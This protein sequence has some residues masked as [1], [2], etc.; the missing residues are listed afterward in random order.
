MLLLFAIFLFDDSFPFLRFVF[1]LLRLRNRINEQKQK[2]S[3][4]LL[5]FR[6]TF[7]P[8]LLFSF[9]SVRLVFALRR[10]L[11]STLPLK[12]LL[13]LIAATVGCFV[14]SKANEFAV[15]FFCLHS[16][17]IDA[18][19]RTMFWAEKCECV[20][21]VERESAV[22]I[23]RANDSRHNI[24]RRWSDDNSRTVRQ[25]K[26]KMKTND[27]WKGNIFTFF[28]WPF[29]FKHSLSSSSLSWDSLVFQH[30]TSAFTPFQQTSNFSHAIRPI[31]Y[32]A[33]FLFLLRFSSFSSSIRFF[34]LFVLFP[35]FSVISA[36]GLLQHHDFLEDP[37]YENFCN[38]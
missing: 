15:I 9:V 23:R 5:I 36:L 14:R 7:L 32:V 37:K 22:Y 11:A 24:D 30:F 28:F 1:Y 17:R 3:R 16:K 10:F 31:H 27:A 35:F 6:S 2:F 29:S 18:K 8:L 26:L 20:I 13:A 4:L 33:V 38:K 21:C 25:N 12:S 34:S 19:A